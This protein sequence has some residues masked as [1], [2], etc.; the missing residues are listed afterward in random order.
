MKKLVGSLLA[1][2]LIASASQAQERNEHK[3]HVNHHHKEMLSKELN[4]SDDQKK[5]LK[6]IN[7][8]FKKQMVELKKNDNITVKEYKSRKESIRKDQHQ[9]M[10]S[11]LTTEQK[12]KLEQMKQERITKAKERDK[13]GLENMKAK[14]NLSDEQVNK[15]NASHESFAAKA[16]EIRS[17][18]SLSSDQKKE[19]FKA[20]EEQRKEE[21]KSILTSEQLEKMQQLHKDRRNNTVK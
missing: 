12:T 14:L 17:N 5:Q 13:R 18:Q 10:Q 19:R 7:A 8:E 16:K 2:T 20:L 3:H 1:L 4:F 6:D 15:L 9:K 11:L 21:A